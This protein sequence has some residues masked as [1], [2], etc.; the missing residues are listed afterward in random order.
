MKASITARR[1]ARHGH[2]FGPLLLGCWVSACASGA[3]SRGVQ[4]WDFGYGN[5]GQ[6]WVRGPWGPIHPSGDIDEVIDQ[7]CPT[8]VTLP[9]A[10]LKEYGQEYFPED[11]ASGFVTPVEETP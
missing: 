3:P 4:T 1:I 9:R 11:K 6:V 10:Q 8:V 5:D 2:L 7:L